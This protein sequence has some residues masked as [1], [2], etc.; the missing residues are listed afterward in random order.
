[1]TWLL[2]RGD[3]LDVVELG[4]DLATTYWNASPAAYPHSNT[5]GRCIDV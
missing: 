1:L 3:Q 2:Q 5:S 4:R